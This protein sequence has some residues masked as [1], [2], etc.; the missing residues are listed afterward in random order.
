MKLNSLYLS[1][2]LSWVNCPCIVYKAKQ[3]QHALVI[4]SANSVT[5]PSYL[6]ILYRRGYFIFL[7]NITK[8]LQVLKYHIAH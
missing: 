1:N 5:C 3:L 2:D 6:V 4:I 8:A 7:F